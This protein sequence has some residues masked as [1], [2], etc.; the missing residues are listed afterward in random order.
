MGVSENRG[1]LFGGPFKGI[2]FYLGYQRGTP[3]LGNTH[4]AKQYTCMMSSA[5]NIVSHL[6]SVLPPTKKR[7][8][9]VFALFI[10][11]TGLCDF[12]REEFR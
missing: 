4:I 2:L 11:S 5:T 7:Q 1:T 9:W 12:N 6:L 8:S 10:R 3:I